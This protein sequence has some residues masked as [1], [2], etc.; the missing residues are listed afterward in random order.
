M[1]SLYLWSVDCLVTP[2][3]SYT[4]NRPTGQWERKPEAERRQKPLAVR[5]LAS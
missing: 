1:A 4:M 5:M 2:V 3:A